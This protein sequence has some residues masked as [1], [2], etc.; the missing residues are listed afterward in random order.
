MTDAR[1]AHSRFFSLII[2]AL[3]GLMF[4]AAVVLIAGGVTS[5]VAS[6]PSLAPS[7]PD[8]SA[9]SGDGVTVAEARMAGRALIE[10]AS[11]AAASAQPSVPTPALSP[12]EQAEQV[13]RRYE[14]KID[15][16]RREPGNPAWASR[17]HESVLSALTDF[18]QSHDAKVVGVDCR[19]RS[20]L[21]DLE[22]RTV[23]A[24]RAGYRDL[25]HGRYEGLNCDSEIHFA[26]SDQ[27]SQPKATLLLSNC[28]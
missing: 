22:W 7:M 25:L 27:R 4:G 2:P 28:Q 9:R 6:H 8:E 26:D 3:I 13:F 18:G 10:A 24:A 15:D 14:Q 12:M 11:N 23:D 16:V 17:A 5:R 20:C 1:R 19:T 21:A